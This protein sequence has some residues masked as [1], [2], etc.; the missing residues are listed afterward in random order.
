MSYCPIL[1]AALHIALITSSDAPFSTELYG[2]GFEQTLRNKHLRFTSDFRPFSLCIK[3]SFGP[4]V[5]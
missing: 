1:N 3:P 5:D 2:R 4:S